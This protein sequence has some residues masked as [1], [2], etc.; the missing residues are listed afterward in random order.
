MALEV[1]AENGSPMPLSLEFR[2]APGELLVIAGRSGAGKTTV[3]RAISG[4][5]QPAAGRVVVNGQCWLD[6]ATGQSVAAHKRRVGV[7]FQAYGLFPHLSAAQNVAAAMDDVPRRRRVSEAARLLALA[8]LSGLEARRPAQLSGGQQQ[9][10]AIARA[11][12]RRPEVLLL[13]EPFSA[14]DPRTRRQLHLQILELR[15]H[16]RMPVVLVTHDLEDARALAD[17]V[18]VIE[19]GRVL[20]TGT[21]DDVLSDTLSL[22]AMGLRELAA[23]FVATVERHEDDGL[24]RLTSSAGVLW[25]PRIDAAPRDA[26]ELRIPAHEV[27]V[28]T[29]RPDHVSALNVLPGV[30]EHIAWGDGP[31]AVVQL[32][33]GGQRVLARV[34]QRSVNALGLREGTPCFA[35]LKALSLAPADISPTG[36]QHVDEAADARPQ[37]VSWP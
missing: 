2:V 16:L 23:T 25:I 31:G 19:D 6:S 4:L 34:T 36:L 29:T 5:W 18:L 28:S 32:R 3:L 30:V 10:V 14:V 15:A 35:I 1:M 13:D 21:P 8:G 27:L 33:C 22:R 24:T 7:V 12:A 37:R 26:V 9:R 11:L 20:Q 17:R